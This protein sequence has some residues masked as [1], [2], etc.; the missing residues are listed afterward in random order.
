[1]PDFSEL[2]KYL[3]EQMDIGTDRIILDE[4]W[5]L[6]PRPAPKPVQPPAFPKARP[7]V[8]RPAQAFAPGLSPAPQTASSTSHSA[9]AARPASSYGA[10]KKIAVPESA[11]SSIPSAF[12]SAETLES[13]YARIASEKLY[14]KAELV[15][16]E[17]KMENPR[18]LLVI[19]APEKKASEN[20]YLQSEAGQMITRMFESL[21]VSREDLGVTYFCKKSVA[22]S[23]LP[24]VASVL[25]KMLEKEVSL[26]SPQ[27]V[28]FFGDGL[29]HQALLQSAKVVDFG[30][31][32][33]EFAGRPAT[34][35]IEPEKM[36]VDRQLKVITW[37][38]HIPKCGFF[39]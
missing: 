8:N 23:V 12:E 18:V 29:L 17:G 35:L 16:G 2:A 7:S 21:H 22:R 33:L 25:K 11:R 36:L 20:G 15:R 26:S 28:V 14:A 3:S 1:M 32:P 30:G 9:P 10:V 13:F 19:Y 31:T 24:Q 37:K 4:P 39:G 5:A 27:T 38:M 6:S 34:A